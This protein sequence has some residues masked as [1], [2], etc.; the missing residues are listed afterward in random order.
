MPSGRDVLVAATLVLLCAP[1]PGAA[2]EAPTGAEQLEQ[3]PPVVVIDTSP[4]PALGIPI[5][6]YPGNVQSIGATEMQNQNRLD[7]SDLLYRNLG[8]VNITGNQGNPWENDLTYRGFLAS[9]LTGSPIG[10]SMYMDGMRF[11][12]GFGDTIN[13][14]LLP[15]SAIADIDI[16]PGSNPIFGL[17]T[18]GG[19]LAVRPKRGLDFPG[20]KLEASGGSFGRWTVNEEYGDFRGPLDWY[21]TFNSL[22]EAGWREHSPSDLRQLFAKVGYQT[23]RTDIQATFV[24]ANNSLTGNGLAP[25]SLLAQERRAVYTFPDLTRNLMYLGNLRGRQWLT[26][27]LLVS[28]NLF[29]RYSTT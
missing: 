11:N 14:D 5:E 19:A 26:D 3:L 29:Y 15:Q 20:V 24:Y 21:L 13:W 25:E 23:E 8:S 16:I 28:G 7:M 18:L 27:D 22:N 1:G 9:P 17:N 6:K 10:L 12:D 2:Q 4:V